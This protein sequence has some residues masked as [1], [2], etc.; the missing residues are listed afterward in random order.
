M[1]AYVV[2]GGGDFLRVLDIRGAKAQMDTL[3]TTLLGEGRERVAAPL[4]PVL[5]DFTSAELL[6]SRATQDWSLMVGSWIGGVLVAGRKYS[7]Q[8]EEP[9]PL[10]PGTTIRIRY[11]FG[12]KG[13]VPCRAGGIRSE[14]VELEVLSGPD[15][16]AYQAYVRRLMGRVNLSAAERAEVEEQLKDPGIRNS[17]VLVMDPRNMLPYRLENLRRSRL[18]ALG[19]NSGVIPTTDTDLRVHEWTYQN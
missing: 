13:R 17:I 5:D 1:P 2:S 7:G 11:T 18:V 15:P 14:C 9:N 19:E 8:G 4:R 12:L 6:T 3:V 16:S 10:E